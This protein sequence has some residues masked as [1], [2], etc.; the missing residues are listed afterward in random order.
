MNLREQFIKQGVS[1]PIACLSESQSD[2]ARL[3]ID[4][5][6]KECDGA[7]LCILRHPNGKNLARSLLDEESIRMQVAM[8]TGWS[9]VQLCDFGISVRLPYSKRHSI[10]HRDRAAVKYGGSLA[11][12]IISL[13]PAPR[14]SG[15]F[16]LGE[17][18]CLTDLKRLE[19]P[20]HTHHVVDEANQPRKVIRV[21]LTPGQGLLFDCNVPHGNL[22]NY[23]A[24]SRVA[25]VGFFAPGTS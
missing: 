15:L 25:L 20:Y 17:F 14:D 3:T 12:L 7:R 24:S 13:A 4:G 11:C 2:S 6:I 8:I 1:Y 5:I 23:S 21:P 19:M 18:S 22:M 10:W 16:F 9:S